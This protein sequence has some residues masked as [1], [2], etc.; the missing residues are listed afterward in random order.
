MPEL[1]HIVPESQHNALVEAAYQH[2]GY[3]ADEAAEGRAF[4]RRGLAP[5]HSHAQRHQGAAPRSSLRLRLAGLRAGRADRGKTVALRRGEN[6]ERQQEARPV[7]GYR[8]MDAA[9]KLADQYGV[10]TV[11]VDNAFHYL[12][13]GG[14]VMD[15][16]KKG[17]IAYT[18]CTAALAEVVPVRRQISHAR[19][20]SAFVGFPDH[21]GRWLSDRDR[22]GDVRR[23]HGP[24]AAA[25]A[26]GQTAPAAAAV[27]KDGNP[28]TDPNKAIRSCPSA[29]TKAT[30]SR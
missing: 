24:R 7:H 22:L 13:G 14:Y 8:A 4:L 23:R 10:G 16:A 29:R 6:L 1:Y 20:Q 9:I 27:D 26:R 25:Q 5:R 21:R 17:Y 11:S 3:H 28:T 12:W 18:N 30:A 2:R 15:A 19:H